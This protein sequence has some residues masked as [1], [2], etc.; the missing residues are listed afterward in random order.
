MPDWVLAIILALLAGGFGVSVLSIF[1]GVDTFRGRTAKTEARGIALLERSWLHDEWAKRVAIHRMEFYRDEQN[2]YLR[3]RIGDLEY[4]IR[5]ELGRDKIPDWAPAP[6]MRT[7]PTMSPRL[8]ELTRGED[9]DPDATD[10]GAT[11][12]AGG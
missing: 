3:N 9:D 10:T 12:D 8:L 6:V 4:I 2:P 11:V 5:T 7:L 1:R